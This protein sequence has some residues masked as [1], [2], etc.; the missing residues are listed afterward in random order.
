[1]NVTKTKPSSQQ[2]SPFFLEDANNFGGL[3][4]IVGGGIFLFKYKRIYFTSNLHSPF[5]NGEVS[6]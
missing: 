6:C 2:F 5:S 3:H 1:M 4:I